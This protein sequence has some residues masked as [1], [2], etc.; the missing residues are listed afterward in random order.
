[1]CF[2]CWKFT[3]H[4]SILPMLFFKDSLML[5]CVLVHLGCYLKKKNTIDWMV[6]TSKQQTF[7]YHSS[8]DWEIQDQDTCLLPDAWITVYFPLHVVEWVTDSS[9]VFYIR[10]LVPF[11]RAPPW[12]PNYFPK[13]HLQIPSSW[14]LGFNKGIG[15]AGG[16][17]RR[18]HKHPVYWNVYDF[19]SGFC[20][21]T[22]SH[23]LPIL[24]FM[25]LQ[26]IQWGTFSGIYI[27][28]IYAMGIY[29]LI[30]IGH[31]HVHLLK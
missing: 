31:A 25:L 22:V 21:S 18:A 26:A 10:S 27:W 5:R 2:P 12:L 7:I 15:G 24:L 19:S 4:I 28:D 8:W 11:M 1:M 17:G 16:A 30:Y 23:N 29:V 13:P 3:R 14:R 20:C 6:Y 9:G